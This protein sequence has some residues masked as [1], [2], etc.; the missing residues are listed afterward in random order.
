MKSKIWPWRPQKWLLDLKVHYFEVR[1]RLTSANSATSEGV[2]GIFS[3][4]MFLKSVHSEERDEACLG[5][6][7]KIFTKSL[8]RGG[9]SLTVL[10]FGVASPWCLL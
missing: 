3:K 4:I 2:Q 6:L 5:F 10:D 1:G 9:Q 7:V 8:H